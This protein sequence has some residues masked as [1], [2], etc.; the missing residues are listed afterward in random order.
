MNHD[1]RECT[2]R[3]SRERI[4]NE[5]N[6]ALKTYPVRVFRRLDNYVLP[7]LGYY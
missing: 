5:R 4:C 1:N 7:P 6:F 2:S 3:L